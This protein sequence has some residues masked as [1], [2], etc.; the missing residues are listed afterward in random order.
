MST[1]HDLA[2]LVTSFFTRHPSVDTSKP[3]IR[4][5]VKTG[6]FRTAE[7]PC[8][9]RRGR[10]LAAPRIAVVVDRISWSSKR[11]QVVEGPLVVVR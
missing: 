9:C 6:H 5:R 8:S 10:R 11:V 3:A 2:G 1:A 4:G 7:T